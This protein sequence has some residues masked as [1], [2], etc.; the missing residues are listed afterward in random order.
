MLDWI[1]DDGGR[2]LYFKGSAG[3]C[4][5]RAIA[6]A[7][8]KDYKEIYNRLAE[9]ADKSCR[10]GTPKNAAKKLLKELGYVRVATMNVGKG[11]SMH[12]T[13]DE[14][15][16]GTIIVQLSKHITCVKDKVIH[17]T[18]NCSI[19]KYIDELGNIIVNDKRCV[20]GYWKKA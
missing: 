7:E 15:P 18:Y 3:D 12:F 6:I 10:N 19:K 20:Y 9:I 13:Q 8:G 11:C 2:S 5:I 1:Y 4:A 16:N 14:I 17:D